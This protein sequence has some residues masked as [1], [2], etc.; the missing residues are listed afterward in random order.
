MGNSGSIYRVGVIGCGRKGTSHA[1][2]YDLNPSTELVAAADTDN[3]NLELFC[4]RFGVPGYSNYKEMLRK[5]KID[6]AVPILPVSVNPDVVLGCVESGVKAIA[7]E[8]PV[9]AVL[10]DADQMVEACRE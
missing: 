3:E 5:E 7:C 1:R 2:A 9:A 10:S 4:K 8:K 6:I